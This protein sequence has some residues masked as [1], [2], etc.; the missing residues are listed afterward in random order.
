MKGVPEEAEEEEEGEVW[1]SLTTPPP[2]LPCTLVG[3]PEDEG[4]GVTEEWWSSIPEPP[5]GGYGWVIVA[6][7]FFCNV[8]VDGISYS[9]G[10]FLIHFVD[11]YGSPK[12]KTAWIGSLLS[13]CY[14]SAGPV[15]SAL[16]NKFGCRPVTIAGSIVA[17]LGFLLS[18]VAPSVDVLMITYG[19]MAGVGFGLIYLPAIVSVGYYFST[20]RAFATGLAVCGSGMGTFVFAP[21]TQLLLDSYDWKGAL[22]IL[23]G[24]ALNC[25]VF[26]ALMQPLEARPTAQASKSMNGVQKSS[27]NK[28]KLEGDILIIKDGPL[29]VPHINTE[30]GVQSTLNLDQVSRIE[31]NLFGSFCYWCPN[32]EPKSSS[33]LSALTPEEHLRCSVDAV[34]RLNPDASPHADGSSLGALVDDKTSKPIAI[35][36]SHSHINVKELQRRFTMPAAM[37]ASTFALAPSSNNNATPLLQGGP[38]GESW[39]AA[40]RQQRRLSSRKDVVRPLYRKDIFY[41]G[42]IVNLPQYRQSKADIRS[43]MQS[44]T[45]IPQDESD[46]EVETTMSLKKRCPKWC[47]KLP[48]SMKHTLREALDFS[49]LK[50]PVFLLM[51]LANVLGMM[52]FYVPF[53]Y[54]TDSSV[55]KGIA[56]D[57]AA[58][59]LSVIGITNLI[60]RLVFGW[61]VDKAGVKAL[62][63][64]NM[65]LFV[66]GIATLSVPFCN[67]YAT[68]VTACVFFSVF[69]SAYISL[70]SIILVEMVGLDRLTN[71]FGLLCLFRGFASIIGPPLAGS[72]YDWTGSY[73][74]PFYLAGALLIGAGM[75]TFVIPWVSRRKGP[76]LQVRAPTPDKEPTTSL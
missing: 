63:V 3:V 4:G 66:S 59:L 56:K 31:P 7:S 67:S 24:L 42:S 54:V 46:D 40:R 36:I 9:F 39:S 28:E 64:N 18:I 33:L 50:E 76:A 25:A 71:S 41:S 43:Y 47:P 32:I 22:L 38:R 8:V 2:K 15:V 1:S 70:T 34:Q 65:C 61:V 44:V 49:L 11:F 68:I 69:V 27:D 45:T 16:T 60:G 20:R 51:C 62:D 30:P 73:D 75:C 14:L 17:C 57:A 19:I 23:A 10:I 21:L 52:G 55:K 72:V 13:G 37:P 35:K 29:K 26:G 6:A 53:V 58:F 5:D 12:G 48:P 74:L